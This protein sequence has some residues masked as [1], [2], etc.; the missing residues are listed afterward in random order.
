VVVWRRDNKT[1]IA[2]PWEAWGKAPDLMLEKRP[3]YAALGEAVL[4]QAQY[5]ARA[6][7][8]IANSE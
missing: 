6:A 1:V 3:K 2:T 5:S 4:A 7:K 8:G